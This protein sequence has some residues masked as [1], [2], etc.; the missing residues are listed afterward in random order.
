MASYAGAPAHPDWYLNLDADPEVRADLTKLAIET[1]KSPEVVTAEA[2]GNLREI[3]ADYRMWM[4][5]FLSFLLTLL[6]ARIYEGIEVDEAGLERVRE[7]GRRAPVVVTPSHKSHIDYLVLSSLFYSHGLIPPHIAAGANLSFFPLGWIFRRGGAFFLRR[8]FAGQPIY[9]SIFRHY[10]RKLLADGHW[11]EFF[12]EGGRSRTGKLLP[13][14]YGLIRNALETVADGKAP[15]IAFMPSNFGYERLIEEKAYRKELEGGEKKAESPVEVLKATSVLVHKYGR[16]RIQFGQ[17]IYVRE[18]LEA[19]GVCQPADVREALVWTGHLDPTRPG[20]TA[21]MLDKATRSWQKAK[22]LA[23]S[24]KL[25][26]EQTRQL[27]GEALKERD[28]LGWS[29]MRDS[30]V[31]VAVA[32]TCPLTNR[33]I[34]V[35][36]KDSAIMFF[37]DCAGSCDPL[38]M[39]V[40]VVRVASSAT[41]R[42]CVVRMTIAGWPEMSR[43]MP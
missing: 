21:E 35:P 8:S 28:S 12:P 32:S 7:A 22:G 17:P 14:K 13:P 19:H 31:G 26:D 38:P 24:G 27:M 18:F 20:T 25:D 36:S 23:Q 34:V 33:R 43:T 15:D 9:A 1:G 6:W 4:V 42:A 16:I 39:S 11:L 41:G 3:G 29:V 5:S 30:A 40:N 37:D 10:V 2:E